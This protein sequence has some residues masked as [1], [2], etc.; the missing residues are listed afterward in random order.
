MIKKEVTYENPFTG[1]QVQQTLYFNINLAEATRMEMFDNLSTKMREVGEL[2][3]DNDDHKHKTY[4]FF[5][6]IVSVAYGNRSEDG[7][8]FVKDEE[9][10]NRFMTSEAYS[11]VL[12]EL[13]FV[14]NSTENASNFINGLFTKDI[15]DNAQKLAA[16]EKRAGLSIVDQKLAE[17]EDN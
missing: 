2:D 11:A 16:E 8:N 9:V 1:E 15:M 4:E 12:R 6:W 14:D 3:P 13:L 5:E 7:I 17:S 10:T